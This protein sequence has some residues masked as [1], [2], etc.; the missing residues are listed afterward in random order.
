[1]ADQ[2]EELQRIGAGSVEEGIDR[3][4][5]KLSRVAKIRILHEMLLE[6]KDAVV[7]IEK[8]HEEVPLSKETLETERHKFQKSRDKI[9]ALMEKKAE[10][11]QQIGPET[12]ERS[13]DAIESD[14]KIAELELSDLDEQR[15]LYLAVTAILECADSEYRRKN[16]PEILAR[17]SRYLNAMTEGK[18]EHVY[19]T[20]AAELQ[21]EDWRSCPVYGQKLSVEGPSIKSFWHFVLAMVDLIDPDGML[22]VVF[23]EAF[24]NWD[25]SRF[26]ATCRLLEKM[27]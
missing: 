7:R 16:Q 4:R 5:N 10:I 26:F 15:N 17:V 27:V 19:M 11:T 2:R 23:D 21:L 14:L 6:E 12:S 22:P 3:V 24:V 25:D 18:Y 13:L 1:M 8:W 9:H 20:E